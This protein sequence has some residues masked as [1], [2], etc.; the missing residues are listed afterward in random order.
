MFS[1][2][3]FLQSHGI[4]F[5]TRGPNTAKNSA[6]IR[7][8]FC[9]EADPSQHLNIYLNT[10]Y[11]KCWRNPRAHSGKSRSWLI[12]H[13][14]RCSH[15]E[16]VRLAEEDVTASPEPSSLVSRLSEMLGRPDKSKRIDLSTK[17]TF[18]PQ[19]KS[20]WR[21]CSTFA[22]P[23]W[24]YLERRGY[25][26]ANQDWVAQNYNLHYATRGP[27]RYRL[28]IPVHSNTG[29]LMTWTARS[30]MVDNPIRY[31]TLSGEV[32]SLY[33]GPT[34]KCAPGQLLLGLPL[35]WRCPNPEVLVLTEGPFDAI[36]VSALGRKLG[37]Y[38]TCL[39]GLNIT[40]S[41][42]LLL[43]QLLGRF[44]HLVVLLDTDAK[45]R[46]FRIQEQLTNLPVKI[47][48]LPPGV[49]DPGALPT[50][51]GMQLLESWL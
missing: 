12:Q 14:L 41:Q 42:V 33:P 47:E 22:G 27:Y 10:G 31:K 9:G 43:E 48:T 24:D 18:P 45:F 2:P 7:C 36:R 29:D 4:N 26:L 1:W 25:D 30:V 49:E 37:V 50:N 32:S 17:L 16:A 34:A 3:K 8:P 5:V 11:W 46:A 38:G 15:D 23:F 40:D 39:F 21:N 28:I 51:V 13:L 20:L 35:L 44:R 6:S 19:F